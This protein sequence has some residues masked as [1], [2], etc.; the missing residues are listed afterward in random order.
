MLESV[1]KQMQLRTEVLLRIYPGGITVLANYD[2][3]PQLAR[4]Q[5]RLV[6]ELARCARRID[7]CNAFRLAAV[8]ARE[9]VEQDAALFEQPAEKKKKASFPRRRSR[10]CQC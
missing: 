3:H 5:K 10:D 8:S 4:D 1:V 7:Q 6:A 9:H 2:R